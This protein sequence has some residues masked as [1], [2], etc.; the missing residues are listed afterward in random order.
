MV[1]IYAVQGLQCQ[2]NHVHAMQ[3]SHVAM[4]PAQLFYSVTVY[5][6][7]LTRSCSY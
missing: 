7:S 6:G 2:Q 4:C 3:D 1:C 5:V